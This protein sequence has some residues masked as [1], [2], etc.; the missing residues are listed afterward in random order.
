MST[1]QTVVIAGAGLVGAAKAA[2]TL[3]EWASTVESCCAEPTARG[4]RAPAAVEGA[5]AR[6][7]GRVEKV[8]VLARGST[9]IIGTCGR[10]CRC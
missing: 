10:T 4:V 6:Q 9:T 1:P 8:F 7:G 2:E 5:H 3:R